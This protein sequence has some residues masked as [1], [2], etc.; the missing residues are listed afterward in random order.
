MRT[1]EFVKIVATE[2]VRQLAQKAIDIQDASNPRGVQNYL[3]DVMAHFSESGSRMGLTWNGQKYCGS[4]MCIQNPI[5]IA[6]MN[7]LNDLAGLEQSRTECFS[8]CMELAAGNDQE[9]EVAFLS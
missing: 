3:K 1:K 2:A 8:V 5:S 7:K 9:W 6:V 4:D